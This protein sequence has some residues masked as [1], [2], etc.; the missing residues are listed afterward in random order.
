MP[1]ATRSSPV[2]E[3]D[4]GHERL[5]EALFGDQDIPTRENEPEEPNVEIDATMTFSDREVLRKM[6][7]EQMTAREQAEARRAIARLRLRKPRAMT[8]R[9]RTSSRGERADMRATIRASLRTGGHLTD[10]KQRTRIQRV[11]PLV[12]LCDISGSMSGYSRL[13]LHF[14]HAITN[15]GNTVHTFVFGTR[16]TNITRHLRT[17]DV[18]D[19]LDRVS[20]DV[21]DWSGGTRIGACLGE[22]NKHWSRRVL[23]QGAHVLLITDG[24]D[25]EEDGDLEAQMDWLHRSC[26]KLIWL[27]PLLRFDGFE[28]RAI[29]I[30][31]M[32]PHVDEFRPVHNLESLDALAEA[33]A[34]GSSSVTD[35]RDWLKP[36]A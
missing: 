34:G 10:I 31:A 26:K 25:R 27:N 36:A 33:L 20:E 14:L 3:P 13:F 32:L 18:D 9:F 16:L 23:G 7:F 2:A 35:P 17:K 15:D 24:L 8:R 4:P 19:A 5:A 6:D 22:F 28:A 12:V 21:S 29:G 1:A 30:R 11:A